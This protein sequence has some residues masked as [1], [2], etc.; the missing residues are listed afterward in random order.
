[1]SL[2]N[3]DKTVPYIRKKGI[4]GY[5]QLIFH[6]FFDLVLLNF[7]F[8]I[9][10]LPIITLGASY[11]ALISVCNK[12]AEDEVVYPIREYFSRFKE[13]FLKSSLYGLLFT[14][15]FFIIAFSSLFYLNLSKD[16]II[17]FLFAVVGA[18]CLM[19]LIMMACWFFPLLTKVNQNLKTLIINSFVLSFSYIKPSLL[20]LLTVFICSALVFSLFPYSV[21]FIAILPFMLIALAS[22]CGAAEKINETFSLKSE[23]DDK[24]ENEEDEE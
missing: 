2:L 13:N 6:N 3:F 15:I 21:P 19:L 7:I 18:I 23:N 16:N 12:Y 11:K 8:M 10:S 17:F 5:F 14:A 4:A 1:M 22:S 24:S 20:Y 9:T